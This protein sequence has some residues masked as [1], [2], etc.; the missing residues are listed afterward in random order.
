MYY[1]SAVYLRR[2]TFTQS[3]LG[4]LT[5]EFDGVFNPKNV[6]GTKATTN[7]KQMFKAIVNWSTQQDCCTYEYDMASLVL[8]EYNSNHNLTQTNQ[9]TQP[10]PNTAQLGII[11][12]VNIYKAAQEIGPSWCVSKSWNRYF[13]EVVKELARAF[14][15]VFLMTIWIKNMYNCYFWSDAIQF[16]PRIFYR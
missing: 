11:I 9:R 14:Y 6:S 1:A 12:I 13:K 4:R 7:K 2:L 16:P 10:N 3:F 5:N 15:F 8:C